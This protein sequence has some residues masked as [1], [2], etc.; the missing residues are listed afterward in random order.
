MFLICMSSFQDTSATAAIDHLRD[1]LSQLI[2]A[3]LPNLVTPSAFKDSN[4]LI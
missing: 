1:S 3:R 4:T 2:Q